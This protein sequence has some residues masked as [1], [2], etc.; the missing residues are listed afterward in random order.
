MQISDLL[1]LLLIPRLCVILSL[2]ERA[3]S[4]RLF[5]EWCSDR[6]AVLT[7]KTQY[8]IVLVAYVASHEVRSDCARSIKIGVRSFFTIWEIVFGG[9][10]LGRRFQNIEK[11]GNRY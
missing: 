3:Q 8:I 9:Y 11:I 6:K 7:C 2:I 1:L 4:N 10:S 5:A